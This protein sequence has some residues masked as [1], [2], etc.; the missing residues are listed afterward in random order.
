LKFREYALVR[1][2]RI[3]QYTT[4]TGQNTGKLKISN[5]LQKK[6]IAIALVVEYQN[7][8]SGSL[9]TNGLN[10]WSSFVGSPLAF[11]ALVLLKR[12]VEFR[13]QKREEEVQQVDAERVC[14]CG[15]LAGRCL[16]AREHALS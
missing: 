7:L 5:Q 6:P 15:V 1:P 2:N 10:S 13:R 11:H 8:N 4:N 9:R 12:G 14:D 3:N 16:N